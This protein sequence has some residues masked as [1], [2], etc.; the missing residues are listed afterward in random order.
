[1]GVPIIRIIVSLGLYW[2]SSIKGNYHMNKYDFTDQSGVQHN[3]KPLNRAPVSPEMREHLQMPMVDG[4]N[5]A[6]PIRQLSI[7]TLGFVP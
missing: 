4:G 2:G 3:P 7:V 5:L 1:M 6:L